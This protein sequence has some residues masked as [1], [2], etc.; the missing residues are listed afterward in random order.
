MSL[1]VITLL[2]NLQKK[3]GTGHS[4]ASSSSLV[5]IKFGLVSQVKKKKIE[6]RQQN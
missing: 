3:L 6:I 2:K 4:R 1:K 5:L